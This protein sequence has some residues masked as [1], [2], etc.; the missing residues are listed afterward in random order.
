MVAGS[1][2]TRRSVPPDVGRTMLLLHAPEGLDLPHPSTA[3][4]P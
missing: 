3:R 4:R 2:L 1:L